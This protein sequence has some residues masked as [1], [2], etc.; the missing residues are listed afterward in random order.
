MEIHS[1]CLACLVGQ[2]EKAYAKLKPE[3]ANRDIVNVQKK[4]MARLTQITETEM[5]YYSQAVYQIL[6]EAMGE[7]DPYRELKRRYNDIALGYVPQLQSLIQE[8]QTPLQTALAIAILGN[9]V[10]FGTPHQ[11]DLAQ[12]IAQFNLNQLAINDYE[13]IIANLKTASSVLI[14]GD[15]CGECV[16]DKVMMEY[17]HKCYP[18]IQFYYAV[19]GGPMINDCTME[20]VADLDLE[21]ICHVIESS[22]SPGVIYD[23]SSAEFQ[24]IFHHADVILAKGQGNF[25]A[26]DT[27]SPARAHLY[28]LLKTKCSFVASKLHVPLGSLVLCEQANLYVTD[29]K[30]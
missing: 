17:L 18:H 13:K 24:E 21:D 23:Q 11:I 28:F 1:C 27:S 10:D 22:A 4:V 15:N 8:S 26:L 9:T 30:K 12:D 25:E 3:I 29:R 6:N 5:P 16:F 20:D 2:I 7:K 19:R 14:I